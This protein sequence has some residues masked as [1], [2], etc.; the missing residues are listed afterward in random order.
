M[1]YLL[2]SYRSSSLPAS[3]IDLNDDA[4]FASA[5]KDGGNPITIVP[6]FLTIYIASGSK[7][8]I[9]RKEYAPSN[10]LTVLLIASNKLSPLSRKIPISMAMISVSV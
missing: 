2:S 10:I 4:D 9:T 6:V 8:E 5:A 3:L 1:C 7:M